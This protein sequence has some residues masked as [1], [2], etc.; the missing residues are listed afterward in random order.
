M[1]PDQSRRKKKKKKRRPLHAKGSSLYH[2]KGKR[3]QEERK[4]SKRTINSTREKR[5]KLPNKKISSVRGLV[6]QRKTNGITRRAKRVPKEDSDS[7]GEKSN[8]KT[9][10]LH[11]SLP[12]SPCSAQPF[13][14]ELNG[15]D[16][17]PSR[18]RSLKGRGEVRV[19]Q[20]RGRVSEK[21]SQT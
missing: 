10:G 6:L 4:G 15:R 2:V 17:L 16:S 9:W 11:T 3:G 1:L 21:G 5:R 14:K 13:R 7:K 12:R 20:T 19:T 8:N 18:L